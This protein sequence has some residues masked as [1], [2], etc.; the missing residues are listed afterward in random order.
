[1][2]DNVAKKLKILF[3][4]GVG[5]IG[6]N[7]TALEYGDNIVIIDCGMSFPTTEMPGIDVVVP[8]VSYLSQNK[9]KIKGILL[10][11]GHEDHIGAIP[12]VYKDIAAPMYGSKLTLALVEHKLQENHIDDY[13]TV[14]VKFRQKYEVGCFKVEFIKVCHSFSGAAAISITTPKGVV[15]F[16]GDYKM[17]YTPIDD[18]LTDIKRIC[19]IGEKGVLLMLGESTNVE[20]EGHSSSESKVG[21][22]LDFLFEQN[23]GRRIIVATFAS[24]IYRVQQILTAAKKCGR[25]VAFSGKSMKRIGEVAHQ[26]G[27]LQYDENLIVD[28][29][30]IQKIPYDK[31]I[32]ICTGSQGEPMSSL[33]RMA[34]GNNQQVSITNKDTVILSSSPIPGN[35]RSIYGVINNL[36]K[37]GAEVVYD[38]MGEVHVSGHA[39]SE[40][41]KLMLSL[42]KPKYFM[43]VHGEYRHLVKHKKLAVEMGLKDENIFLPN[44]GDVY[45]ISNKVV[46]KCP[47][48]QAGNIFVDGVLLDDGDT[49]VRDRLQISSSGLLIAF[50]SVNFKT[51]EITSSP[52][53]ITRGLNF[54]DS[55]IKDLKQLIIDTIKNINIE[56]VDDYS[57]LKVII[58]KALKKVVINTYR[59]T[60]MIMPIILE[61]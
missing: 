2:E 14:E 6:K 40:E 52:E 36:Y 47:K 57:E 25:R 12:Y 9:E 61:S 30:D 21:K 22:T 18:Q 44:I 4:G 1:M 3:L 34:M 5:E 38:T 60:P 49:V 54:S 20:R 48:I 56:V 39:F 55:F 33:A 45:S 16:T 32:I 23:V 24:N 42:V 31:L 26:I 7:M 19:E 46:N 13:K 53:I 8:D 11:H 50:L 28:I 15:F 35:E 51:G 27:E 43:P 37:K 41:L 58:R 10:T 59:Q 29:N 17:D